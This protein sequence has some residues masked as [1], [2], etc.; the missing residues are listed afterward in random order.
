MPLKSRGA[1]ST[2]SLNGKSMLGFLMRPSVPPG[3]GA[4]VKSTMRSAAGSP[5]AV[6]ARL[7]A[8]GRPTARALQEA[9][10]PRKRAKGRTGVARAVPSA[11]A[12]HGVLVRFGEIGIKSAPVR[13]AMVERL[14]QN[15]LDGLVRDGV[16]G[17]VR[18]VGSRLWMTGPDAT[19]LADVACRT[20][21]VVSASPCV[22]VPATMDAMGAAAAQLALAQPWRTFAIRA[23]REGKHPFS[24]RSEEHT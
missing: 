24:S 2:V 16:E 15:L 12:P 11:A 5:S 1:C 20:F 19:A 9:C 3:A 4:G 6:L 23:T 18:A 7:P 17:D 21:G 13:R 8:M 22:V 14:R 10:A